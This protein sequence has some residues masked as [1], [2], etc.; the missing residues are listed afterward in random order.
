M[1]ADRYGL[2]ILSRPECLSLL[3]GCSVGRVAVSCDALPVILPVAYGLLGE[4]VVF[5]AGM[6]SRSLAVA[7]QNVIA[8]E[9]DDIDVLARSGWSVV[10]VGVGRRVD[11]RDR[12]WRAA[13]DLD[14]RPWGGG[15]A[16]D[17]I[18]LG[19]DRL[20]G[21]RLVGR[22]GVVMEAARLAARR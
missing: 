16:V 12:D 20:C 9:V 21:R 19:S 10:A 4:D 14:V 5:A 18:R 13:I 17:L 3:A 11:E 22:P 2:E 1:V 8:F 6:G 7:Y 15:V